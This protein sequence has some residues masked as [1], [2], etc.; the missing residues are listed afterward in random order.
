MISYGYQRSLTIYPENPQILEILI[1]TY[2]FSVNQ[3]RISD[4]CATYQD[5]EPVHQS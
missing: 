2:L 4:K 5:H 1:Q 3:G